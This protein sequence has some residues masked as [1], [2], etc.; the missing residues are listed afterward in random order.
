M[1]KRRLDSVTFEVLRHRVEEIVHE[2]YYTMAVVSGNPTIFEVGDHEEAAV[3]WSADLDLVGAGFD[4][5][6]LAG[7]VEQGPVRSLA[8]GAHAF[9]LLQASGDTVLS[10]K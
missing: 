9:E 7:G 6:T 10:E 8:R 5:H 1:E 2:M 3:I 4:G